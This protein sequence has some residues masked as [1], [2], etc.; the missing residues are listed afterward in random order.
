LLRQ[1]EDK[2]GCHFGRVL[3][4]SWSA[5]SG[6]IREILK[7]P[8][9]YARVDAVLLIDS[10]HAGYLGDKPGPL[11]SKLDPADLEVWIPFARDAIAGHKRF[12]VRHSEIFPGTF[13]S[14]TKTAD[15]LL[16]QLGLTRRA[17]LRWGPMGMQ[18]LSEVKAGRFLLWGYAGNPAPDHVD[19]L[20]S[21]PAFLKLL[22][23]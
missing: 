3:L 13:A 20:Q 12:V 15:Y 19:K 22:L 23:R 8:G 1:A 14:T 16:A 2:C 17:V 5:C 4:G 18:Q 21:L 7:T 6:A 9:S 10:M 11:E